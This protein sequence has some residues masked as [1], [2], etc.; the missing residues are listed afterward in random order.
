MP[1]KITITGRAIPGYKATFGVITDI[2]KPVLYIWHKNGAPI[3]GASSAASYTT[4]DLRQEDLGN[5]YSVMVFGRDGAVEEVPAIGLF[6]KEK[7]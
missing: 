4:P 7:V 3:P 2:S 6:D 1:S 5:K